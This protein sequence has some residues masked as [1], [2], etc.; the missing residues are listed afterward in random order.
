MK[1]FNMGHGSRR[2][3]ILPDKVL[4]FIKNRGLQLA[5]RYNSCR[6]RHFNRSGH[7][8]G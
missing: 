7:L 1:I 5:I 3:E 4:R 2:K 6:R 8:K